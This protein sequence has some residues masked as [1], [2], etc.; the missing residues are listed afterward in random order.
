MVFS[1]LLRSVLNSGHRKG[2]SIT[3]VIDNEARSYSTFTPTA[4]AVIGSL[5][6]PLV[7]RSI[8]IP[9][10]RS[11]GTRPLRRLGE[12]VSTSVMTLQR[13]IPSFG[14]GEVVA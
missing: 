11:D 1:R 12:M 10:R 14:R 5:P 9:M 2:G 3:R 7:S 13:P 6:L 4:I 8:V